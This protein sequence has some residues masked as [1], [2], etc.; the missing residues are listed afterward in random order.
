MLLGFD[1]F[2]NELP[3]DF[4]ISDFRDIL[5]EC[6][7][8][9]K[10]THK[11]YHFHMTEDSNTFV[12]NY[13]RVNKTKT[14]KEYPISQLATKFME[15]AKKKYKVIQY[16]TWKDRSLKFDKFLEDFLGGGDDCWL[17]D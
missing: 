9:T 11:Y 1:K 15:K 17:P 13:G 7:D 3:K 8:D 5:M 12:V 16:A 10:N 6:H 2:V 14:V 4:K